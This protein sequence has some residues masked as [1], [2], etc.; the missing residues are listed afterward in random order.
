M[1]RFHV[2]FT[3]ETFE[4]LKAFVVA[5]YGRAKAMSMVIE[6]AVKE[7]LEREKSKAEVSKGGEPP[8]APPPVHRASLSKTVG[9]RLH[10]A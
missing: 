2:F 6:E 10:Q 3:D 7:Y 5:K 9:S 4:Q 8:P 1:P